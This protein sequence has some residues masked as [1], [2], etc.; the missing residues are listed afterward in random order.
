MQLMSGSVAWCLCAQGTQYL[1]ILQLPYAPILSTPVV[2]MQ[3]TAVAFFAVDLGRTVMTVATDKAVA[4]LRGEAALA[5]RAAMV[6][7][8][9]IKQA[10]HEV[11]P[12]AEVRGSA[13]GLAQFDG[14]ACSEQQ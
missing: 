12:A 9:L 11:K 1:S 8:Q 14:A 2:C 7:V 3:G 5:H 10:R 13:W 6:G 4:L